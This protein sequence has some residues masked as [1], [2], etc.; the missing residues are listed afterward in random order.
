MRHRL[1]R[2]EN[3][4]SRRAIEDAI[5][6]ATSGRWTRDRLWTDRARLRR[7]A[8][9]PLGGARGTR[10]A[11]PKTPADGLGPSGCPNYPDSDTE[12]IR[13]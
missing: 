2:L 6:K 9:R 5:P 4:N 7:S 13:K 11:G 1:G 10:R 12:L 3:P 8:R